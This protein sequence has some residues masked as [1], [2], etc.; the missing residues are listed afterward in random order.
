ML[1]GTVVAVAIAVSLYFV[2]SIYGGTHEGNEE[3]AI[4][5][6][7]DIYSRSIEFN[8]ENVNRNLK[9][10]EYNRKGKLLR[11]SVCLGDL[12]E[13]EGC[14]A[15]LSTNNCADCL[16][17]E[18]ARLRKLDRNGKIL[19]IFDSPVHENNSGDNI[20]TPVYYEFEDGEL[21]PGLERMQEIPLLLYVE[22]GRVTA[23]C[24]VSNYSRPITTEFHN[25]LKK[26]LND[27]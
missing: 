10:S 24:P 23:S 12:L 2:N 11:D 8:G 14:I 6:C 17:N 18:I 16:K 7:A 4:E 27:D 26:H 13:E 20:P 22:D 3:I 9:L 21:L 1:M 25:F 15:L 5:N 19:F